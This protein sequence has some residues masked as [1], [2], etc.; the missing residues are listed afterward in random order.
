[1]KKLESYIKNTRKRYKKRIAGLM[2]EGCLE[3]TED[4]KSINKEWEAA[5]YEE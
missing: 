4:A 1:M 3:M 5:D 2:K